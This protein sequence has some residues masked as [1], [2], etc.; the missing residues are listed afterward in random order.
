MGLK[1]QLSP[2]EKRKKGNRSH[3]WC[4]RV[5]L[6]WLCSNVVKRSIAYSHLKCIHISHSKVKK[7]SGHSYL[8]RERRERKTTRNE[9]RPCLWRWQ[10]GS[11]HG[12]QIWGIFLLLFWLD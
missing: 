9:G 5:W 2:Q 1:T 6:W 3:L 7:K 8:T 4:A 10:T 11:G 12:F